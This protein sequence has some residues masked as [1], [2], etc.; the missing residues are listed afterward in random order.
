[1]LEIVPDVLNE[2]SPDVPVDDAVVERAGEVHHGPDHNLVVPDHRPLLDLVN[3]ENCDLGPVDDVLRQDAPFLA[4]GRD[5][6][7]GSLEL[8]EGELLVTRGVR[9]PL[10]FRRMIS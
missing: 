3:P 6:E 10:Y 8:C 1:M 5:R 4:E 7:R 9:E 2:G